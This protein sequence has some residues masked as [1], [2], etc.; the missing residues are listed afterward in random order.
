MA[1]GGVLEWL[2]FA[3]ELMEVLM[4]QLNAEG[5]S[6]CAMLPLCCGKKCRVGIN[7]CGICEIGQRAALL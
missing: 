6:S 1:A 4:R 2:R 5:W 7:K 3:L